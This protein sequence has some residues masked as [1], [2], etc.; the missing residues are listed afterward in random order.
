MERIT[1]THIFFWGSELSNWY[2]NGLRSQFKYKGITF[3]NSEQAFMWEKAIFFGDTDTAL[4]IIKEGHDPK[5]SKE[6]GRE[7]RNFNANIWLKTSYDIMVA[8]NYEKYSQSSFLRNLLCE[9]YPKTLVEASPTDSIW[10]IGLHWSDDR[11]LDERKWQ[12]RNLLGKALMDVREKL[13][14]NEEK[15][16]KTTIN[17]D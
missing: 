1:D 13:I 9:T 15:I 7:V 14:T 2:T 12:G 17:E 5:K 4:K 11:V 16:Y 8:V 10:G 6:L 3:F